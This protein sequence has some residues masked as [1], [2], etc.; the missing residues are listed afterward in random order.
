M[1]LSPAQLQEQVKRARLISK[2]DSDPT[3]GI[4]VVVGLADLLEEQT[5][6]VE[7]CAKK[8][9]ILEVVPHPGGIRTWVARREFSWGPDDEI[10]P[11]AYCTGTTAIEAIRHFERARARGQA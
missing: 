11:V 1:K 4:D 3:F 5:Q 9:N 7:W 8:G 6:V 2:Y 10:P